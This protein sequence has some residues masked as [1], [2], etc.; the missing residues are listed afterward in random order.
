MIFKLPII[1]SGN[2]TPLK[3]ISNMGT[4]HASKTAMFSKS[5]VRIRSV[6]LEFLVGKL[7]LIW[8]DGMDISR[9]I[10]VAPT[11]KSSP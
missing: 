7:V 2:C 11:G 10:L 4:F 5:H 1:A 9:A 6:N 8:D 3:G